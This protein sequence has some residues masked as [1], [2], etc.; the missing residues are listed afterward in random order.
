MNEDTKNNENVLAY[1]EV[2]NIYKDSTM[3]HVE[4]RI[5]MK[6][7]DGRYETTIMKLNVGDTLSVCQAN[8]S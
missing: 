4:L 5:Y 3:A 6:R 2:L 8:K 1:L 7:N